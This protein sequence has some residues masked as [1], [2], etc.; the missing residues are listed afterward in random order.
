MNQRNGTNFYRFSNKFLLA[1][2]ANWRP[3]V[4]FILFLTFSPTLLFSQKWIF[5]KTGNSFDGFGKMAGVQINLA[6]EEQA[7]LAVVN[8]SDELN[9]ILSTNEK[10]G[11]GNLSVRILIPNDI[12]PQKVLIAFDEERTN[13]M[14]NFSY[15]DRIIF[16]EN[17]VIPDFKSFLSLLDIISFFKLKKTVHFRVITEDSKYNYSFPLVGSVA[18]I[19]K[20]FICPSYKREGDWR[21]IVFE[22][23]N[24]TSM[25]SAVDNGKNNFLSIGPAC[26]GYLEEKY[27]EYFFTQIK[28]IESKDEGPLPTLI[29]KNGQDNIVAEIPK[30]S[31]LKNY[32]HFSGNLKKNESQKLL[33]DVES[34]KLYYEAFQTYTNIIN[35]KNISLADFSNLSKKELLPYY[36]SILKN[37]EFLDYMRLNETIYYNYEIKQYTFEVFTEAW[38]E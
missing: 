15:S 31:Y 10:N 27:G 1:K 32:F 24:F 34:I 25:F 33:K 14:L 7:L 11:I 18:A 29:F 38:G 22:L 17:A 3:A 2:L 9:L 5:Q 26:I 6:D 20:T 36:K 37:R 23:L 28:S 16:I 19:G 4:F 30:A 13:Y 35:N 12:T 21:D 8:K